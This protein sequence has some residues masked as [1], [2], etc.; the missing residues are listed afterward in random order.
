[1]SAVSARDH[2]EL[3]VHGVSGTSAESLLGVKTV[4][5]P[6]AGD[7][8]VRFVRPEG[9]PPPEPVEGGGTVTDTDRVLEG[10]T[11][12]RLTSGSVVQATWLLLLPF[13]VVNLAYWAR[14]WRTPGA[15]SAAYRFLVRALGLSLTATIAFTAASA[16]MDVIGWQCAVGDRADCAR[17]H[18]WLDV[19]EGW[20]AGQI[21][22]AGAL[23]PAATVL[24][25]AL[26]SHRTSLRY[27]SFRGRSAPDATADDPDLF[28]RDMWRGDVLVRRLRTLH[29][30]VGL[31]TTALISALATRGLSRGGAAD[32][33]AAQAIA[34]CA[35]TMLAALVLASPRAW[36]RWGESD[37]E[38]DRSITWLVW[39]AAGS[40]LLL[41]LAA[42]LTTDA[43]PRPVDP[44][45]RKHLPGIIAAGHVLVLAQIA[46]LALLGLVIAV[47]SRRYG[48]RFGLGPA[49]PATD[50][51]AAATGGNGAPPGVDGET[52]DGDD[53]DRVDRTELPPRLALWGAA[54][55]FLATL[56]VLLGF[57]YSSAVV[58][59]V[60]DVMTGS[61]TTSACGACESAATA[62]EPA[63]A[64][65]IAAFATGV[66]LA[67]LL[68]LLGAMALQVVGR[69]L[70]ALAQVRREYAA[71]L[72]ELAAL[73]SPGGPGRRA[74]PPDLP[75]SDY[76][77]QRAVRPRA[78][79]WAVSL[80][81]LRAILL[82]A[83][84]VGI[85]SGLWSGWEAAGYPGRWWPRLPD[86]LAEAAQTTPL[87]RLAGPSHEPGPVLAGTF[88]FLRDVGA[89]S[90]AG[91]AVGGLALGV[92]AVRSEW[93]RR[94]VGIVWDIVSFW[95]R[96]GHPLAPPCYAERAVPQLAS[97]VEHL[98]GD[99]SGG[100]AGAEGRPGVVAGH[101]QGSVLA[102]A[103]LAQLAD[104]PAIEA[105]VGLMTFGSPLMRLYAPTF[106]RLFWPD[107]LRR[108][109]A[110]RTAHWTTLWRR[111]D[112]IGATMQPVLAPA[113]TP[114]ETPERG[115][116]RLR[117]PARLG[118]DPEISAYPPVHGH[119]DYY[120]DPAYRTCRRRLVDRLG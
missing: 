27:E 51:Q 120:A 22:A 13:A 74:R 5:D 66:F 18:T 36:A 8:Y 85:L 91:L 111:T 25:L 11:W 58:F 95:P 117:D 68:A 90:V 48:W 63:P 2:V 84:A 100:D 17:V 41:A 115:D 87:A 43:E 9:H 102:V 34:I 96:A 38:R 70:V 62:P 88:R 44:T 78:F 47:A 93:A 105:R 7:S 79:A 1:M 52:D 19:V 73:E 12:G 20:S 82:A 32:T 72:A 103:A 37:G 80:D 50:D 114:T 23:V 65:Q 46:L 59:R 3:R 39:L 61:V 15:L 89:W 57:A 81:R 113:L 116:L 69:R 24:L 28:S 6:V 92:L 21:L 108:L 4:G 26:L 35:V 97:R 55:W 99:A 104:D 77:V 119:L 83:S 64:F 109:P 56:S 31:S 98:S 14:P 16:T 40:A 29:V 10:M 49:V 45:L 118:M 42:S 75:D 67:V 60:A 33:L 53:A 101:S 76:R 110:A 71:E 86:E 107:Q 112:P 106:P 94:V 54:G 30:G